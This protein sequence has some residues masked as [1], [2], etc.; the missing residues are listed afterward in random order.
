MQHHTD[1]EQGVGKGGAGAT[2]GKANPTPQG[3]QP[4]KQLT[5]EYVH[6]DVRYGFVAAGD[7]TD[8][9]LDPSR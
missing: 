2:A 1:S 9:V 4:W 8:A 3:H 5:Y 7:H 6:P